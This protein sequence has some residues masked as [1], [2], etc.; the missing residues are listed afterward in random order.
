MEHREKVGHGNWL[1]DLGSILQGA[2]QRNF[3][4]LQAIFARVVQ[5]TPDNHKLGST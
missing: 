1:F 2:V 5:K 4:T 3:L